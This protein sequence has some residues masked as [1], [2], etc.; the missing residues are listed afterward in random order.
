MSGIVVAGLLLGH[1]LIHASY[2][3]PT[4]V[5]KPGAPAWPFH[6]ER[7][8]LLSPIG[9]DG[10]TSRLLGTGLVVVVIAGF[11]LAAIASLGAVPAWLWPIGVAFGAVASLALLGLYFHPWLV[12]GIG[13]DLVLLWSVLI[14]GWSPDGLGT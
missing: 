10:V 4:P 9:L 12:L 8:W 7:S 13:I 5:P 6:V 11:A 2:L 3:S 1:A 14:A